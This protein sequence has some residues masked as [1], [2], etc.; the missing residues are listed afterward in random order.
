MRLL[1]KVCVITGTGGSVGRAAAL[2]FAREGASVVGCHVN[3]AAA[4]ATTAMVRAGG[5]AM[6]SLQPCRLTETSECQALVDLAVHAHGRID[7]LFNNAATAYFNWLEDS[8][9]EEWRRD[10]DEEVD[11]VFYPTRATW[12]HLKA[13][14]G[15]V[16][17]TASLNGLL[18][19]SYFARWHIRRRRRGSSA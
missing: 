9:D 2:A 4:E 17:N 19:S 6:V 12:P 7:V 8:T 14:R 16:V 11:L 5:A 18:S 13:S 1:G 10:L 15:V 3:V